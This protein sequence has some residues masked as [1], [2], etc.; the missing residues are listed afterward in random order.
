MHRRPAVRQ[1]RTPQKQT[2]M[3]QRVTVRQ[4]NCTGAPDTG[5][6]HKISQV[7]TVEIV[8]SQDRPASSASRRERRPSDGMIHEQISLEDPESPVEHVRNKGSVEGSPLV[9]FSSDPVKKI[10]TFNTPERKIF[11]TVKEEYLAQKGAQPLYPCTLCS[12]SDVCQAVL[13]TI[14]SSHLSLRRSMCAASLGRIHGLLQQQNS[15]DP[16]TAL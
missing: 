7:P 16:T 9:S 11:D 2:R 10:H 4:S 3:L 14:L 1:S 6:M 12:Q 15:G 13:L 5:V 8:F